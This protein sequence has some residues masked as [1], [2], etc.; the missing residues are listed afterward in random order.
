MRIG[1]ACDG[2][3]KSVRRSNKSQGSNISEKPEKEKGDLNSKTL[4][5]DREK[6]T[7]EEKRER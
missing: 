7:S 2:K 4:A 5:P 1:R 6:K 3:K